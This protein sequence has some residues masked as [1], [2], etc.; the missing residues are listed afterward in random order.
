[1]IISAPAPTSAN[2]TDRWGKR[3]RPGAPSNVRSRRHRS[4]SVKAIRDN[5]GSA[6]RFRLGRLS[7]L[8]FKRR[9]RRGEAERAFERRP[10]GRSIEPLC[11]RGFPWSHSTIRSR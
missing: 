10:D 7:L 9:H 6:D 8:E 4:C 3:G 5:A 11:A 2:S 1:M